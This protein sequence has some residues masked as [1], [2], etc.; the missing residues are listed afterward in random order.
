MFI[1]VRGGKTKCAG[2]HVEL[3]HVLDL[4]VHLIIFFGRWVKGIILTHFFTSTFLLELE[5]FRFS[6]LTS[7]MK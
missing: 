4:T 7:K 2:G 6:A 1:K 3:P 5:Y